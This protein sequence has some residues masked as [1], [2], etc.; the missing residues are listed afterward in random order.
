MLERNFEFKSASLLSGCIM[1]AILILFMLGGIIYL[2]DTHRVVESYAVY[3][4]GSLI[5]EQGMIYS[6]DLEDL[7]PDT[8]YILKVSFDTQNTLDREDDTV[9]D[10]EVEKMGGE[11]LC[12]LANNVEFL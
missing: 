12:Q 4:N 6:F 2:T 11:I 1:L 5:D 7:E 10:Y 8:V 3:K 9:R